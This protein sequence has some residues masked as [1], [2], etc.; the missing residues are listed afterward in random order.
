MLNCAP[1]IYTTMTT[2]TSMAIAKH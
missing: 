1:Q 2:M